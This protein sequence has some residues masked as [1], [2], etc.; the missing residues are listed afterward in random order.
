MQWLEMLCFAPT[1]GASM[2]LLALIV[3][4]LSV[5]RRSV[6]LPPVVVAEANRVG[7]GAPPNPVHV[8][9]LAMEYEGPLPAGL[10]AA[11]GCL[12]RP[13]DE[14]ERVVQAATEEE[15]ARLESANAWIGFFAQT[16]PLVG[17]CSAILVMAANLTG[18]PGNL[19]AGGHLSTALYGLLSG[20]ALTA[21]DV[22]FA[23]KVANIHARTRTRINRILAAVINAV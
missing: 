22:L 14:V 16:G 12:G 9:T 20:V 3:A 5:Y 23:T 19:P 8:R 7:M 21:V 17:L 13:K 4:R 6:M 18:Q 1:V 2:V 10:Q 15:F 11:M